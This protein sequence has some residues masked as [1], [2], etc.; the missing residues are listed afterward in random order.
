MLG[1]KGC[2]TPFT[3]GQTRNSSTGSMRHSPLSD[4]SAE[5]RPVLIA[6]M[7]VWR[8]TPTFSDA[9]LRVIPMMSLAV[10]SACIVSIYRLHRQGERSEE[11]TSELQSLMR[12]SYV[13]FCLKKKN[14][15]TN[16]SQHTHMLETP[17]KHYYD[18]QSHINNTQYCN[19][20]N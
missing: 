18:L 1:C 15:I 16:Q 10:K 5:T 19:T 14:N 20:Y 12:I 7:S 2:C 8:V 4:F 17:I 6:F 3:G 11:H 9:S 13:V